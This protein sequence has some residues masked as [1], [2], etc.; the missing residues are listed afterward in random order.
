MQRQDGVS[1]ESENTGKE[2]DGE[3]RCF[4][5]MEKEKETQTPEAEGY[6]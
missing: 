2:D 1:R 4:L 6:L 3:Y 5:R